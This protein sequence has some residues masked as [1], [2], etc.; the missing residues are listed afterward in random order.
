[1]KILHVDDEPAILEQA[2]IFLEKEVERFDVKT[3]TSSAEALDMLEENSFDAVVADYQMPG[4]DGLEFLEVVRKDKN[5]DIPFIIFT[6]KG[7][8]KVAMEALNLGADRYLQKGGDSK[9]QY[10]VLAQAIVQEVEHYEAEKSFKSSEERYRRLFET[11]QD[12]MLILDAETG[13]VKDANPYIQDL[14]GYSKEELVGKE[15]WEIGT[16]GNVVE[17]R[18]RFNKLVEEGYI[19]YEDLPLETKTGEE[20]SVEF[21]SNTYEAGGEK[22]VQCNIRDVTERKKREEELQRERKRFR[23]IFNNVNDAIYLHELTEEGMPGEFVEVNDVASEMLGYSREELLEMSPR[24]IDSSE[25]SGKLSEIMEELLEDGNARFEM[26]HRAKNGTEIPVEIHSHLFELEGEEKVLS[27]ARDISERKEMENELKESERE[28]S[29]ILDSA[30]EIIAYHDTDHKLIWANQA[31]AESTGETVDD[32]K[33]RKCYDIWLGRENPC[34]GCPVD[35]ALESG[36]PA[37]GEMSPPGE[38]NHW[39]IRGSPVRDE[40][41]NIIGAIETA[42]DITERKRSEER[43]ARSQKLANVGSWEIELET[44]ELTWS[45]ETYRIFGVPVGESIN[46]DEFLELIHPD[47]R[48]YVDEKWSEALETGNYDIEHRIVVDGE[49]K[50]VR[51]KADI[52]LDEEGEPVEAIGSVQDITEHKKKEERIEQ[53]REEY[54]EL[55][56][57]MNDTAW[58]I[59]LDGSFLEVNEAAIEKLGYSREEL[60]SMKPHDI[61]AELDPDEITKLIETMPEDEVQVFE[62]AH[63]TK[64][65]EKIPVEISSSLITYK[66]ETAILSI[67][68]DITERKKVEERLRFQANLLDQVENAVIAT[69]PAGEITYWN[70]KAEELYGWE[71]EEVLGE[72]IMD[73]TPSLAGKEQAEDIM[74]TLRNGEKWSG[75]FMVERKDGTE[76][77]AIVT[78]A[79]IF[80]EEGDMIGIVGVSTDISERKEI[81]DREDFLHSLLRHDLRNKV[82]IVQGYLELMEDYDLPEE[83][84]DHLSKAERGMSEGVE[85]IE[86]VRSL[87]RAQEEEVREISISSAV[88][89]AVD[90][91]ESMAEEV[92]IEISVECP[93][94]Y[95]VKGGELLDRVFYNILENS[96]Q[97]SRGSKIRIRTESTAEEIT[98]TV[99]DDGTGISDDKKGEIFDRGY[100]TDDERGTGLGLFLVKTLLD[101]YG[102]SI[103]VKDSELGGARFDVRLLKV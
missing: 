95:R 47:D 27:V 102:G 10:G 61:D 88:Q 48:D 63:E 65:G 15:L 22:V 97:H 101:I 1:M 29:L 49:T 83:A 89:S 71:S 5:N 99:E 72:N 78:D 32:V 23:K 25:N 94:D 60:L 85:I 66:G 81:E 37:E 2:K 17:N 68:R 43:L 36:E 50:W 51:E 42:S 12:G 80:D 11:A 39:L 6:G 76:F 67:A 98:C 7:R 92:N 55:I 84:R 8:E 18:E 14:T 24:D 13:E 90:Q 56:D 21:V 69:D 54:K 44:G 3:A 30:S 62:T 9:T 19:R 28:K 87:R 86:K 64:S 96:I 41:G 46:Y 16:F 74:S 57:G 70:E 73:V 52:I 53:S 59:G 103:E 34:D 26:K 100:T 4:M 82:Q 33:G 20:A 58:V 40:D 31:F 75:E 93:E 91:C 38:K 77:P 79:P 35:A 45:E